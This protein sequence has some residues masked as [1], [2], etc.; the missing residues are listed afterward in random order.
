MNKTRQVN[1]R[2]TEQDYNLLSLRATQAKMSLSK[3]IRE[4][5]IFATRAQQKLK[6]LEDEL[7]YY[8]NMALSRTRWIED[9][10]D[11]E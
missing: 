6:R 3:Y 4:A 9:E 7:K 8:K 11:D 10:D 5:A 2:I 1:I